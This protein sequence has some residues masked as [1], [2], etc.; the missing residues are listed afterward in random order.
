MNNSTRTEDD[1][2]SITNST[3]RLS[4][5]PLVVDGSILVDYNSKSY[6]QKEDNF[7][8]IKIE[9][10]D[11]ILYSSEFGYVYLA[12]N[13][14]NKRFYAINKV[15]KALL[16]E[17][18]SLSNKFYKSLEIQKTIKHMNI[19]RLYSII[20]SK[21]FYYIVFEYFKGFNLY[22]KLELIEKYDEKQAFN[23]IIQVLSVLYFLNKNDILLRDLKL[24]SILIN[25]SGVIKI[26]DLWSCTNLKNNR[27]SHFGNIEYM[28]PEYISDDIS[29]CFYNNSSEVWSL[30]VL[31]YELI[32][33]Q[34]PFINN[35]DLNCTI[36]IIQK[37]ICKR[38]KSL[39]FQC[40]KGISLNLQNLLVKIF[41]FSNERISLFDILHDPWVLSYEKE[42]ID[43]YKH[44]LSVDYQNI[45][46]DN[47]NFI[48]KENKFADKM[49]TESSADDSDEGMSNC[50]YN[51]MKNKNV[52]FSNNSK[53]QSLYMNK[54][55]IRKT[56]RS[57]YL[58]QLNMNE[59]FNDVNPRI[60]NLNRETIFSRKDQ[61]YTRLRGTS[62]KRPTAMNKQETEEPS[63][64]ENNLEEDERINT[65]QEL[66]DQ[67]NW[68]TNDCVQGIS[69]FNLTTDGNKRI[70]S[71]S[72]NKYNLTNE[73]IS[74]ASK[75]D[76]NNLIKI[77]DN[78][79]PSF[80]DKSSYNN[81]YSNNT[82]KTTENNKEYKEIRTIKRTESSKVNNEYMKVSNTK[83]YCSSKNVIKKSPYSEP[84]AEFESF[85]PN[86]TKTKVLSKS[87]YG[88]TQ[89]KTD[90]SNISKIIHEVS[91][92]LDQIEQEITGN[93]K[94]PVRKNLSSNQIPY[95]KSKF[96]SLP[97]DNK[98]HHSRKNNNFISTK[99]VKYENP[100]VLK[101]MDDQSF[102]FMPVE[103]EKETKNIDYTNKEFV[104]QEEEED[105]EMKNYEKQMGVL[106]RAKNFNKK[107]IFTDERKN[108]G[109]WESL[110]NL[111]NPFNCNSNE[112]NNK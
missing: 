1:S 11:H 91:M 70:T 15:S 89:E 43:L 19:I 71:N 35:I 106:E 63:H 21:D 58:D 73:R 85:S 78:S 81:N 74:A 2:I 102:S 31:L 22:E 104:I 47:N 16:E 87:Q 69:N 97:N 27:N 61:L 18:I 51:N 100:I 66:Y 20:D 62:S 14:I 49:L 30:G 111:F 38:I 7:S 36:D 39:E 77:R 50:N 34:S 94:N 9:D 93:K 57:I 5:S 4:N 54:D 80:N 99:L 95:I 101:N 88:N 84:T 29:I 3:K 79:S 40:D 25:E 112:G 110:K 45:E 96:L 26:N 90:D 17:D 65:I 55:D 8:Y 28:P 6:L 92:K 52:H 10:N 98:K 75:N 76:I 109:I 67:E 44:K 82:S 72:N 42:Y 23:I 33:G 64:I 60:S 107:V 56:V 53:Q 32:H 83:N 68:T 24:E 86:K 59:S 41:K 103:K 13:I 108:S 37:E 105:D 46:N 48:N 12:K